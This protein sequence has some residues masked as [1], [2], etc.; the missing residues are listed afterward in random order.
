[1]AERESEIFSR[2]CDA[3]SYGL[4]LLR[5]PEFEMNIKRLGKGCLCEPTNWFQEEHLLSDPPLCV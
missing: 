2:F 3:N 4:V 1:M 5:A